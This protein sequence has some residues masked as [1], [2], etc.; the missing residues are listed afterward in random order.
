MYSNCETITIK[1]SSKSTQTEKVKKKKKKG[2]RSLG[3][4]GTKKKIKTQTT[5]KGEAGKSVY[6]QH[7]NTPSPLFSIK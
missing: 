6:L 7:S 2:R 3:R 5:G 4:Q 1:K